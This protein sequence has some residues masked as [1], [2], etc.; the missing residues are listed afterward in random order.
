ML[1]FIRVT[2]KY[3]EDKPAL[4]KVSFDIDSGELIVITGPSGSGKTTLLKLLTKEQNPTH[5]EIYFKEENVNAI[6]RSR[7]PFH[8]RK[9]GAVFQDYKLLPELN[10]WENIAL[11]LSILGHLDH[12]IEEKVTD[13]LKLVSLTDK[14]YLF[15]HQLSGGEAQRISIARALSTAPELIFADEPTGNLDADNSLMIAKLLKKINDLGTTVLVTT[16]D[17]VVIKALSSARVMELKEGS[18]IGQKEDKVE[19]KEKSKSEKAESKEKVNEEKKAPSRAQ[20]EKKDKEEFPVKKEEKKKLKK[21][22]NFFGLFKKKKNKDVIPE[23]EIDK[24]E[25]V[26]VEDKKEEKVEEKKDS[27]ED[28]GKE[29]EDKSKENSLKSSK[30]KVVKEDK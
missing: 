12:E 18:L 11:A 7:V 29:K 30:K 27:K 9:I 17:P 5:G 14:A 8:R 28:K 13:L 19:E 15:P 4:D 22:F 16:H 23:I 3:N 25:S 6:K 2:K 21:K 26:G 10:I 24:E 20:E 1:K